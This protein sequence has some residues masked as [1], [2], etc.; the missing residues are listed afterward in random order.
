M[1][2]SPKKLSI[3]EAWSLY[4]NLRSHI[5]DESLLIDEIDGILDTIS[6]AEFESSLKILYPKEDL[7]E[8]LP[9]D[10]LIK[11]IRGIKDSNILEFHQLIKAISRK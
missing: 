8:M 4:G 3:K 9:V 10:V 1:N 6:V 2:I 11:F 7:K 5:S